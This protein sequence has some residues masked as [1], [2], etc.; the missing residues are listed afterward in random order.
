MNRFEKLRND[1][2][3]IRKRF[4]ENSITLESVKEELTTYESF[5]KNMFLSKEEGNHIW[6]IY[7]NERDITFESSDLYQVK[8]VYSEYISGM[9][10]FMDEIISVGT[11]T[12]STET[13]KLEEKF[14]KAKSNDSTFIESLCEKYVKKEEVPM[15]HAL[16][17]V[18]FLVD[19]VDEMKVLGNY[20]ESMTTKAGN[21]ASELSKESL[22]M[23]YES[24]VHYCQFMIKEAIDMYESIDVKLNGENVD[25]KETEVFKLF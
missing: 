24:V 20:C 2:S 25:S 22:E 11:V 18:A 8:D 10:N 1:L 15:S 19:F 7:K 5:I 9:M 23:L 16:G 17:N 21:T 12:E 6:N 3:D 13:S 14:A 4:S